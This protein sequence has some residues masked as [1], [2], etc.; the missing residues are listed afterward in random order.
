MIALHQLGWKAAAALERSG[1]RARV[2]APLS[3]SIYLTAAGDIL[4]L[5]RAEAALHPR[6]MLTADPLPANGDWLELER[7]AVTPW[8]PA[9]TPCGTD[10]ARALDAG[11]RALAA[12]CGDLG[13]PGGFGALL[14]G[15]APPFPLDRAAPRARALG[16]ACAADDPTGALDAATDL[17]GLGPGLT[18]SGDDY[19]GGA[20]FARALLAR[21]GACDGAAWARTAAAVLA[22]ARE[23]THPI[24]AAVLGDMLEGCGHAPLHDLARALTAGA[25]R[26]VT[27]SAA[28]RLVRIGHSSG[29]DMLA[30]FV[31]GVGVQ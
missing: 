27:L 31:A 24:S 19:V 2:L 23:R 13:T 25:S 4:W 5:G 16:A 26:A 21:S 22:R 8:R 3:E 10:A 18:P 14:I 15:S 29:W 12:A 7:G 9:A 1:G 11:G 17:L 28:R 6:A 20:F 30:G